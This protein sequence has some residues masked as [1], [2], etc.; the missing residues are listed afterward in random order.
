MRRNPRQYVADIRP[1]ERPSFSRISRPADLYLNGECTDANGYDI[2]Q[3]SLAR[4]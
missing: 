2:G 4:L 1:K 3:N